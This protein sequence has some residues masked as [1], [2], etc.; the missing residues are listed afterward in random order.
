MNLANANFNDDIENNENVFSD[1][2]LDAKVEEVE[3]GSSCFKIAGESKEWFY[4]Q[5]T[6]DAVGDIFLSSLNQ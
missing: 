6:K 1:A 3:V 5:T 4:F 2:L